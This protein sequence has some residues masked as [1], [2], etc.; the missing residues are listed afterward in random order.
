[1]CQNR[2]SEQSDRG[3]AETPKETVAPSW[4]A[5]RK[6]GARDPALSARSAC[7]VAMSYSTPSRSAQNQFSSRE[8]GVGKSVPALDDFNAVPKR[9]VA[10]D[11]GG[12]RAGS[13]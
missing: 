2:M 12:R 1:M 13:A 11:V 6:L 4:S 9:E 3:S 7:R 10:I 8:L 5:R